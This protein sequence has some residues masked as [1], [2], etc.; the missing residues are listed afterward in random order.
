MINLRPN[1]HT[2]LQDQIHPEAIADGEPPRP[3][4]RAFEAPSAYPMDG[5]GPMLSKAARAVAEQTQAAEAIA[6]HSVLSIA[7]LSVQGLADVA[8]PSGGVC[9]LSLYL[10]S[11]AESGDRKTAC[12]DLACVPIRQREKYDQRR[13]EAELDDHRART[14][15]Y[16]AEYRRIAAK[17]DNGVDERLQ[18]IQSL[19]KPAAKPLVP[20]RILSEPTT[21]GLIH[22]LQEGQPSI[23]I[24]TSE[25]GRFIGGHS[26]S[27][28]KR[29]HSATVLSQLWNS[30]PIDFLRRGSGHV[31]LIGRRV[32]VHLMVQPKVAGQFLADPTL[33]DQ[34]LLS[35]MLVCYPESRCGTRLF[36]APNPCDGD[37]LSQFYA[38]ILDISEIPLSCREGT[39]NELELR[40]IRFGG[41]ASTAWISFYN[42]VESAT[43][44]N[45]EYFE[46]RKFASKAAE[47][48]A[49]LAGTIE[50]IENPHAG[51]VSEAA[52]LGAIELVKY[53]LKEAQRLFFAASVPE[54]ILLSE[55]ALRFLQTK[56]AKPVI[57]LHQLYQRGPNPIRDA[58]TAAK[59]V[60]ILEEHGWLIR[61]EGGARIDGR[62]CSDVWRIWR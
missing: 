50:L 20:T 53:Y 12:D 55:K 34:G 58:R 35:R 24:I 2:I 42:S 45:G 8:R 60:K 32:T 56:W 33:E 25:G 11:I 43:G 37:A 1:N 49:R 21:E 28:E 47:Q 7:N 41:G 46:T 29:L 27:A 51:E 5:L 54:E 19:A 59:I 6:A 18:S 36:R 9:P 57:A 3:L 39:I 30:T 16:E 22:L 15:L 13:Y 26:M 44:E 62:L 61:V 17:A 14:E 10:M 31:Y 38:R 48:V 4:R 40:S 23:G 52:I